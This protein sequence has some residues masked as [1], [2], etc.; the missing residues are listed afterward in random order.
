M[1][2]INYFLLGLDEFKQS[3]KKKDTWLYLGIQDI[4]LRYRRSII[5]PWWVTISSAIMIMALGFLYSN[6]FVTDTKTYLPFFAIGYVFWAWISGQI[7][8]AT[9]GF[10][11]FENAIKQIDMPFPIYLFRFS[12]RNFIILLHNLV[13]VLLVL[14]II[15]DGFNFNSLYLLP[16]LFLIQ[17]MLLMLCINI[18][19]FC[20]RFRDMNQVVMTAL[21]I[22][23]FFS[24]I[25][26]QPNALRGHSALIT[27]N[28]VYHWI[29]IIR[30]PLL[31]KLATALDWEFVIIN[32]LVFFILATY[33]LG[34]FKSRIAIW[35]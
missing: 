31:G 24:P 22:I 4:K 8:D 13:V 29:E 21:Q 10:I 19:I 23:F 28:P 35:L 27:F 18:S 12:V 16:A 26:W 1:A 30:E 33:L 15:G 20:T 5:G 3:F 2:T 25:L 9:T 14:C 11:Q 17:L 34:R 32:T 7:S 6:I